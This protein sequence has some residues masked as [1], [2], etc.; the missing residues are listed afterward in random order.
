M[1]PEQLFLDNLGFF[2]LLKTSELTRVVD[3]VGSEKEGKVFP[4][5]K[6][7]TR[8]EGHRHFHMTCGD[9]G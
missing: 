2:S 4:V 7:Q 8:K 1:H 3:G 6:A 9:P 5:N